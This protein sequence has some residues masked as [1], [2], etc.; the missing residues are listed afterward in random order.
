[1]FRLWPRG[2]RSEFAKRQ[3]SNS[4]EPNIEIFR[5]PSSAKHIVLLL[6]RAIIQGVVCCV[7]VWRV[8]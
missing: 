1:M 3:R 4:A 2:R 6:K 7:V 8:S 5:E